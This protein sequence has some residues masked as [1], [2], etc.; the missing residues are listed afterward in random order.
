MDMDSNIFEAKVPRVVELPM[1]KP[2]D[3]VAY[4]FGTWSPMNFTVDMVVDRA[5]GEDEIKLQ[6]DNFVGDIMV[7]DT[8]HVPLGQNG[9]AMNH[10][11]CLQYLMELKMRLELLNEV[12]EYGGFTVE[13]AKDEKIQIFNALPHLVVANATKKRQ[14][15]MM[16]TKLRMEI[17]KDLKKSGVFPRKCIKL[18]QDLY[19]GLPSLL[20]NVDIGNAK[21]KQSRGMAKRAVRIANRD[22]GKKA[23][24]QSCAKKVDDEWEVLDGMDEVSASVA[25]ID[26]ATCY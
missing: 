7:D 26:M 17:L 14:L 16:E 25:N 21:K 20:S 23:A 4:V 12:G 11:Q 24:A 15:V 5:A 10:K 9:P 19:A 1:A 22:G 6:D 3:L 13:E 8:D 18:M 2:E